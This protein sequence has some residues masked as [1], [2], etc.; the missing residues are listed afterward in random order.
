MSDELI[1]EAHDVIGAARTTTETS[2]GE[3]PAGLPMPRDRELL[4]PGVTEDEV[5]AI[6]LATSPSIGFYVG[7][8][9]LAIV[10]PRAAAIGYLVIAVVSVL[11]VRGDEVTTEPA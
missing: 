7:A 2:P 11:R 1:T 4:Q 3:L 9:A 8:L 6:L 10:A 5:S